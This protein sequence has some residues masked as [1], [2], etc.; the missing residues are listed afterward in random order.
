M[1]DLDF[2]PAAPPPLPVAVVVAPG[3]HVVTEVHGFARFSTGPAVCVSTD[4][5]T[6]EQTTWYPTSFLRVITVR[7]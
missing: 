3:G 1:V 4:N 2:T 5:G 7:S 6:I